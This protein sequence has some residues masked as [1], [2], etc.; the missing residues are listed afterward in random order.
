MANYESYS[1]NFDSLGVGIVHFAV[2]DYTATVKSLARYYDKLDHFLNDSG[3]AKTRY[4]RI[5]DICRDIYKRIWNLKEIESFFNS[6][7]AQSLTELDVNY[8]FDETKKKLRQK[9]YRLEIMG[10]IV[11]SDDKGVRVFANECEGQYGKY[12]RYRVGVSGKDKDGKWINGSME[13]KFKKGVSVP[14]KARI[15]IKSAFVMPSKSGEKV[16]TNLMIT[17]FEIMEG[18]E[19]AGSNADEFIKIPENI[20][21]EQPFL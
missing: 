19:T 18:G 16:Y 13:C 11:T 21:E 1:R 3:K 6:E 12:T 14:N 10:L 17:D 2:G 20:E 9:G 7:W 8:L 5:G 15:K 4:Q